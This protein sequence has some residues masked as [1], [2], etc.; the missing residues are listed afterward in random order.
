MDFLM[1]CWEVCE[2]SSVWLDAVQLDLILE[3]GSDFVIFLSGILAAG[4][5]ADARILIDLFE[6]MGAILKV[7][8]KEERCVAELRLGNGN[9]GF[10]TEEVVPD[11]LCAW[12]DVSPGA[13][14]L[15]S[16]PAGLRAERIG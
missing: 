8:L 11:R 15:K 13:D 16:K 7:E 4:A 5:A 10:L 2:F 1:F 3:V 12:V 14:L 6:K 9:I